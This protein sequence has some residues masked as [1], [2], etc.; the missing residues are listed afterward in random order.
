MSPQTLAKNLGKELKYVEKLLATF[1]AKFPRASGWLNWTKEFSKKNLYT[2]S[3]FGRRRNLFGY[4][5]GNK[6]LEAAC[7][8]RSANAP[9]QGMGSDIAFLGARLFSE[10]WFE[11]LNELGLVEE[12]TPMLNIGSISAMVHDSIQMELD[13][14]LIP[15]AC[16][17]LEYATTGGVRKYC[18]DHFGL[19]MVVSPEVDFDIGAVGSYLHGWDY[20]ET[21]LYECIEK[22]L[23]FQ[24]DELKMDVDVE[25]EIKRIRRYQ[26]EYQHILDRYPLDLEIIE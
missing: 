5:S 21:N 25:K 10:I 26:R 22:G 20:T 14:K 13:Y 4:L 6:T 23:I 1:F 17:L 11:A 3:P 12:N 18:K 2:F 16:H 7:S 15:L 24:R 9:V 8:R 19:D